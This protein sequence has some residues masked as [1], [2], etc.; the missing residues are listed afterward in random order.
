MDK[1]L[2]PLRDEIDRIVSSGPIGCWSNPPATFPMM[3]ETVVF[4][5]DG[6]G[7]MT[8]RSG[9]T[10]TN[11][12]A[13]EWRMQSPGRLIMR[14]G[15]GGRDDDGSGATAKAFDQAETMTFDIE[16]K[17]QETEF[18]PW[19]VMTNRSS[20]A[21]GGLWCALARNDPPLVMPA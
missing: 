13:F 15:N 5:A 2:A 14:F 3:S 21:F 19:P 12:R 4:K 17:I 18:G 6:S 9:M 1:R 11:T 16:F 20:D 10:G 7:L 8:S